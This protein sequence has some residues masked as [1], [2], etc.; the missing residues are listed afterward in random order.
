MKITRI[1]TAEEES[2]V[3]FVSLAAKIIKKVD[4]QKFI[5]AAEICN[6]PSHLKLIK[7]YDSD[8]VLILT[9][10]S[11]KMEE[12]MLVKVPI[13]QPI[14]L[15]QYNISKNIWPCKYF[16]KKEEKVCLK[17]VYNTF[18]IPN[19]NMSKICSLF[20]IIR[21]ENKVYKIEYDDNAILGHSIFKAIE[22]V[23][24]MKVGYCCTNLDAF[25]YCEPCLSCCMA[26]VHGRIRRVFFIKNTDLGTFTKM[27][28]CYNKN[29]NHRYNVYC[30]EL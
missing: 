23:S 26:F 21:D 16:I 9:G 6:L 5:N 20:C 8:H 30:I 13:N 14:T 18:E 1:L 17:Y 7:N 25:I 10:N 28:L 3:Q 11:V 22:K 15:N 19:T 4:I 29:L 2:E 12:E 24:M 27:K